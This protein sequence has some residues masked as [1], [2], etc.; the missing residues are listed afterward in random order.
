MK[1]TVFFPAVM[2][3]VSA[4]LN[5]QL[6]VQAVPIAN[7]VNKDFLFDAADVSNFA[8]SGFASHG[9]GDSA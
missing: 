8:Q 6:G 7:T 3:A 1:F 4:L 9:G 5:S 2:F